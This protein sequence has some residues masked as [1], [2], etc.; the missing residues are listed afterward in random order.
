MP[1]VR[2]VDFTIARLVDRANADLAGGVGNLV[3]RVVSMVHR[4]RAGR[5]PKSVLAEPAGPALA[6][7]STDAAKLVESRLV[8]FDLRGA[9]VAVMELVA[10][11]NRRIERTAPWELARAERAGDPAAGSRLDAVL[12]DLLATCRV[13]GDLLDPLVPQVA[14]A[15]RRQCTPA[16]GALPPAEPVFARL[17]AGR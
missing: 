8:G 16:D 10:M 7:P 14:A 3:S 6:S 17:E 1:R 13:I 9:C 4:Y 2:D 15:V 12:A 11:A 5:P